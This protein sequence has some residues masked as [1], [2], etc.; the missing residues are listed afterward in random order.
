MQDQDGLKIKRVNSLHGK[1]LRNFAKRFI[2]F[3]KIKSDL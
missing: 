2:F 3:E 1:P